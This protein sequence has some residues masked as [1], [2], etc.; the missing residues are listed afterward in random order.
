M[1]SDASMKSTRVHSS[2][3][4]RRI[5]GVF[6][7]TVVDKLVYKL[8]RS[9]QFYERAILFNNLTKPQVL[10]WTNLSKQFCTIFVVHQIILIKDFD[11]TSAYL[12]KSL[13]FRKKAD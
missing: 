11:K 4:F 13:Y 9:Q 5:S 3:D 6:K 7:R 8:F 10:D 1:K 2:T 12:K